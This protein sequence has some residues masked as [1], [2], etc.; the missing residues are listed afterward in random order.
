M[1]VPL[2]SKSDTQQDAAVHTVPTPPNSPPAVEH[3]AASSCEH[4]EPTQQAPLVGGGGGGGGVTDAARTVS[5][6][7]I[8]PVP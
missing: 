2:P 7:E 1:I 3:A 4:V 5:T 8:E 6:P